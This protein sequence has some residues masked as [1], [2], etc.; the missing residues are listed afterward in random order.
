MNNNNCDIN[1]QLWPHTM[2]NNYNHTL[3][4]NKNCDHTLMNNNCNHTL[5]YFEQQQLLTAH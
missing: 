5:Q 2:N 1:E 3:M 4:N